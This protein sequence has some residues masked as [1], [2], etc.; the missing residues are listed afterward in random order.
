MR[1]FALDSNV[2]SYLLRHDPVVSKRLQ[3]ENDKGNMITIPLL[4]Y[5]KIKRTRGFNASGAP[6]GAAT[7]AK[8]VTVERSVKLCLAYY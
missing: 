8:S 5:Y 3:Q 1:T 4:V 7:R 6:R 2:V